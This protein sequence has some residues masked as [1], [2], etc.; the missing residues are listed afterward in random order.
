MKRFV[1][2]AA[3]FSGCVPLDQIPN[4]SGPPPAESAST[5][6][7]LRSAD[8][9]VRREAIRGFVAALAAPS[10][11]L[12]DGML[13][14]LVAGI[15]DSD[16]QVRRQAL[17]GLAILANAAELKRAGTERAFNRKLNAD[18]NPNER[19]Y[20]ALLRVAEDPAEDLRL[21]VIGTL[22]SAFSRRE[23]T[24]DFLNRRFPYETTP[25]G[26]AALVAAL[27]REP[28]QSAQTRLHLRTALRG[29]D[30]GARGRAAARLARL[31]DTQAMRDIVELLRSPGTRERPGLWAVAAQ[32]GA[33]GRPF[34]EELRIAR[35]A[36]TD[37]REAALA[38]AAMTA[39]RN[40]R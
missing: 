13:P 15:E 5:L 29:S 27:A 8:A 11:E 24:E 23:E 17:R 40:S 1:L 9:P 32:F 33:A 19:L 25:Q 10:T 16:E 36:V 28:F 18:W 4:P 21:S 3:F 31:G 2:A 12:A 37:P 26:S 35:N 34:L 22:A 7:A 39:I 14:A 30:D 20:R 38:D 6:A